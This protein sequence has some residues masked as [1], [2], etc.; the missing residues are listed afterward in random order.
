MVQVFSLLLDYSRADV[1]DLLAKKKSFHRT[2]LFIEQEYLLADGDMAVFPVA[3]SL[4]ASFMSSITLLGLPAD[5]YQYG[6]QVAIL[7]LSYVVGT[8]IAVYL[9]L[10][11][12]FQLKNVSAYQVGPRLEMENKKLGPQQNQVVSQQLI[13][14]VDNS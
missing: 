2:L 5:V 7:N 13:A 10:P 14:T 3:F 11:V 12:F 6:T 9:Y 1:K 8:P 4:M